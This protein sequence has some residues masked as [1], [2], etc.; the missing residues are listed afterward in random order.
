LRPSRSPI[1]P[2]GWARVKIDGASSTGFARR[3]AREQ[4]AEFGPGPP[5]I[6]HHYPLYHLGG[7]GI[8]CWM[9]QMLKATSHTPANT[10]VAWLSA[11]PHAVATPGVCPWSA[12]WGRTGER[13]LPA[14]LLETS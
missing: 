3:I 12:D 2:C 9:P 6:G 13:R 7:S 8:S 14:E 11:A 4:F 1:H 10:E 5:G